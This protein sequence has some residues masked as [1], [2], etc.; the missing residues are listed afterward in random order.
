MRTIVAK[1][2]GSL[3]DL[4]DLRQRLQAFV[5]SAIPNRVLFVPGGGA[6]ADVIRSLDQTHCLGEN[7]SH[8]LALRVLSVNAHFLAQLLSIPVV[9]NAGVI[10]SSAVL[11]A[12]EFCWADDNRQGSLPHQWAVTSDSIAARVGASVGAEVVLLKSTELPEELTWEEAAKQGYVD[13]SFPQIA[14]SIGVRWVNL[15]QSSFAPSR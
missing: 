4:P 8:W 7:A 11:D 10:E 6:G 9:K 2:G 12:F 14:S 1:V 15:R 3:F 5:V 13:E